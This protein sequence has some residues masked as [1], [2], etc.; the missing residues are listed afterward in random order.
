MVLSGDGAEILSWENTAPKW[1][2]ASE[3]VP[4]GR[5]PKSPRARGPLGVLA[6]AWVPARPRYLI[7]T[8]GDWGRLPP[9][10]LPPTVT[11]PATLLRGLCCFHPW[12]PFQPQRPLAQ[13]LPGSCVN[14]PC[15]A[16]SPPPQ[17]PTVTSR[18]PLRG[19]SAAARFGDRLQD[20]ADA[21][22]SLLAPRRP[23]FH[24]SGDPSPSRPR[25]TRPPI[26]SSPRLLAELLSSWGPREM[27]PDC[28][29]R[30]TAPGRRCSTDI[31]GTMRGE[32]SP[33]GRAS[34]QSLPDARVQCRPRIV[35]LGGA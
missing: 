1:Q 8:P 12:E 9:G 27:M 32:G 15:L 13:G 14:R 18:P 5:V 7:Y 17:G 3:A 35:G 31:W 20:I 26:L 30:S 4:L 28:H 25:G 19:G 24:P 11:R 2:K 10:G 6:G 33:S 29:A 16:P 21:L 22:A 23:P 34:G